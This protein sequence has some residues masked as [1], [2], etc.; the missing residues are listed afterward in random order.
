M[1]A[2]P[3][4]CSS[5]VLVESGGLSLL[6]SRGRSS[7]LLLESGIFADMN[8]FREGFKAAGRKK[9]QQAEVHIEDEEL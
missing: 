6:V 2:L 8:V 1:F 7:Y 3:G 9:G 5:R 4:V